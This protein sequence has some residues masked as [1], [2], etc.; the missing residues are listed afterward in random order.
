MEEVFRLQGGLG[1]KI[2][3]ILL[4][5][6]RVTW[7]A[8]ELFSW[9][10]YDKIILYG[11][12]QDT[13]SRIM[14]HYLLPKNQHHQNFYKII[15]FDGK[16]TCLGL[17][18]ALRLG[19]HVHWMY[20]FIFL[21][22]CFIRIFCTRSNWIWIIFKQICSIHHQQHQAARLTWISLT[23]SF[24]V[25][26]YRLS[27]MVGFLYFIPC[28]HRGD[29]KKFLLVG[30][31]WHIH[32]KGSIEERHLWICLCSNNSIP[33]VLFVLLGWFLRWEVNGCTAVVSWGV[34]ARICLI[35][36]VGFLCSSHLAFSQCVLSLVHPYSSTDTTAAWKK[37][38]SISSDR[39]DF[40]IIDSLSIAVHAFTR[41]ILTSLSVDE[42]LLPRYVILSTNFRWRW[43]R[44]ASVHMEPIASCCLLWIM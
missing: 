24:S 42:T 3:F 21:C 34:A 32:V 39:L 9:P 8:Y 13:F 28:P 1:W 27:L 40:H 31:C 14:H 36:L 10:L 16:S 43:L 12:F 35:S 22:C 7:S 37:S 26:S 30:K 11:N 6:I 4:H 41:H 33:Q 5:S 18:H 20:R 29:I 25:H 19:N 44:S 15:D 23:L 38:H 2:N 17:F